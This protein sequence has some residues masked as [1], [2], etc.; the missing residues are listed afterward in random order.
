MVCK[1]TLGL[2]WAVS[3][4]SLLFRIVRVFGIIGAYGTFFWRYVNVP[5]NWGYVGS[6]W[7]IVIALSTILPEALYPFL[8][9]WMKTR[10]IEW[11]RK[12]NIDGH[13]KHFE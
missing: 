2:E 3:A 9:C 7:T 13:K 11:M 5:E 12:Y 6:R 8:L 4:E 1:P 10:E